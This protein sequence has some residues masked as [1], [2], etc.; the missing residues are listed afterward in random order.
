MTYDNDAS[1]PASSGL[2]TAPRTSGLRDT[3][4]W[5]SV[6]LRVV[7]GVQALL[8][9]AQATLAGALLSGSGPA[10]VA[11][12]VLGTEIITWVGR[13]GVVLA[14]L[15]W[16]PARGPGW[17]A[18]VMANAFLAVMIQIGMGFQGVLAVHIPLGVAILAVNLGVALRLPSA[19]G[20]RP[21]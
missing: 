17:P 8:V 6:A 7:A 13:V 3:P 15:V 5:P 1:R 19:P 20:R 16:R 14:V 21:A 9:F 10:R 12:E 11:H 2:A 18:L 4:R